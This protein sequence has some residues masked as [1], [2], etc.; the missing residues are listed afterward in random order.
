MIDH[1]GI[2]DI[3][4]DREDLVSIVSS[5]EYI[6]IILLLQRLRAL[7]ALSLVDVEIAIELDG[8]VFKS[9]YSRRDLLSSLLEVYGPALESL[10]IARDGTNSLIP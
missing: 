5:D 1:F 4:D 3:D 2:D 9:N 10:P 7:G 6:E 8:I